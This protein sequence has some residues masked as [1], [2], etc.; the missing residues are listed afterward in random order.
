MAAEVQSR[1][2]VVLENDLED[3]P[4]CVHGPMLLFSREI[5]DNKGKTS[6]RTEFFGC[7][8]CRNPKDCTGAIPGS[9]KGYQEDNL[10]AHLE[11]Y[12]SRK[13]V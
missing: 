7:S 11:L 3:N 8:A 6:K 9:E 4:K 13:K 12:D 2:R 10:K 5:W 1:T